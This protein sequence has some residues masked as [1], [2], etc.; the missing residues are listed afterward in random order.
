MHVNIIK[1]TLWASETEEER[2]F[3]VFDLKVET[4]VLISNC[5][6]RMYCFFSLSFLSLFKE[7]NHICIH[8]EKA[9]KDLAVHISKTT[10]AN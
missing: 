1:G 10:S 6:F 9:K 5:G 4:W 8:V 2:L 3:Y 7:E